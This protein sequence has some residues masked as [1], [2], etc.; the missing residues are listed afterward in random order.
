M[1]IFSR[2]FAKGKSRIQR[3]LDNTKDAFAFRPSFAASNIHYEVADKCGAISCGGIGA[4]HRLAGYYRQVIGV[5][6]SA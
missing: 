6:F 4:I 5:W 2:W 1:S 3:R